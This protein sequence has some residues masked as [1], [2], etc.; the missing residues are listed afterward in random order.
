[1]REQRSFQR[2]NGQENRKMRVQRREPALSGLGRGRGQEG[3]RS[4]RKRRSLQR[5]NSQENHDMSTQ[6]E[7]AS[8]SGL[9]RGRGQ[10]G[11]RSRA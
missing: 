4:V 9:G 11:P 5:G 10:E 2:G 7:E 8:S 6:W 1:M 3:P